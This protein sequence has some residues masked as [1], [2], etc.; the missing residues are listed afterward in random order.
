MN[1]FPVRFLSQESLSVPDFGIQT[2]ARIARQ[3]ARFHELHTARPTGAAIHGTGHCR[4]FC[5]FPGELE[6][7]VREQLL[8]PRLYIPLKVDPPMAAHGSGFPSLSDHDGTVRNPL[9]GPAISH[10]HPPEI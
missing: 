1:A 7:L 4:E 3:Q 10:F 6:A 2:I 8:T 9:V 5:S